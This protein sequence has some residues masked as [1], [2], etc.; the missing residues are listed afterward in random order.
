MEDEEEQPAAKRQMTILAA[1][2][3]KESFEEILARLAAEDNISINTIANSQFI[4]SALKDRG[5]SLPKDP[6]RVMQLVKKFHEDTVKKEMVRL[7][8]E[9][10][11]KGKKF[12]ITLDEYTSLKNQRYLNIT[13]H[14]EDN[15]WDL[16]LVRM[17]DSCPA[18]KILDMTKMK[19]AH[20]N[21]DLEKD[22]VGGTSDG[23]SVMVRFG[24]LA[25]FLLQLC[26]SHGIHLGI[27]DVLYKRHES[28]AQEETS[29]G[30]EESEE[31][32]EFDDDREDFEEAVAGEEVRADLKGTISK[33]RK[34][35][36]I[37]RQSPKR[38]D[39]L[40]RYVREEKGHEVNLLLDSKTRWNS[41]VAM[42][43]RFL[44]ISR[45]VA[46]A[47]IDL[48]V[49]VSVSEEEAAL[50]QDLVAA[51]KPAEMAS[52][53]LAAR[54]A[55]LLTAEGIFKFL[56]ESLEK[57]SSSLCMEISASLKSRI[58]ARRQGAVVSLM[59]YLNNPLSIGGSPAFSSTFPLSSK[60]E[61]LKTAKALLT[62]LFGESAEFQDEEDQSGISPRHHEENLSSALERAISETTAVAEK[63]S[64][65]Y[66]SIQK[67]FSLYE[68]TGK[69]TPN[70][71]L[72][73]EALL[74]L[75]PTSVESERSFSTAGLFITKLRTRLSDDSVDK[76]CVLKSYF[77]KKSQG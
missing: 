37:F 57:N 24:K 45:S 63:K 41:L 47:L 11:K 49:S 60:R 8:E 34:I 36:K 27:C 66:H 22:I 44:S 13:L 59:R 4:R 17:K 38:N 50:L 10:K 12:S 70:L 64:T 51:L 61:L 39:I 67:E 5:F 20:F 69:L 18:E 54:T 35:S 21:L 31:E 48:E 53:A 72:L 75:K 65:D 30:E 40:Q 73:R 23:A 19:L 3:K 43:E 15:Y 33:V 16:G 58:E 52:K 68:A 42:V 46:K 28:D 14:C 7:I 9:R 74:T 26:F 29:G 76:L 1:F 56:F 6:N 55:T 77:R 2:K 62:R 25:P 71:T 32:E